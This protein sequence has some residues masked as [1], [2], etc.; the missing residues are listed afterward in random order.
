MLISPL[1]DLLV[2]MGS[3]FFF[4]GSVLKFVD[5]AFRYHPA[6]LGLSSVDFLLMCGVCWAFALVLTART[7]VQLNEPELTR[8]RLERLRREE[9]WSVGETDY[10]EEFDPDE[11]VSETLAGER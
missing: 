4:I 3:G 11:P 6:I 1:M 2:I 10:D 5:V 9:G 7:W 8:Q